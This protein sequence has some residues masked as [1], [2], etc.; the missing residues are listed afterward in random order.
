MAEKGKLIK[1]LV[2][3]LEDLD[4]ILIESFAKLADELSEFQDS[5]SNESYLETSNRRSKNY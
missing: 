4:L 3:K 5:V 2:N 1:D